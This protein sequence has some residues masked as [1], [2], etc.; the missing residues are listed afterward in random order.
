MLGRGRTCQSKGVRGG[1]A[2]ILEVFQANMNIK[3]KK[4]VLS[5]FLTAKECKINEV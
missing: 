2:V 4:Y 5:Q 1:E 3:Y